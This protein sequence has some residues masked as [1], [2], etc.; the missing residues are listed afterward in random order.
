[1]TN[2]EI[3]FTALIL[4]LSATFV[5]YFLLQTFT[6]IPFSEC[7]RKTGIKESDLCSA[8]PEMISKWKAQGVSPIE[9]S[10]FHSET[11]HLR[12]KKKVI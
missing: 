12:F 10:S 5:V 1:M 11:Y 8:N 6:K 9:L 4:L 3:A 2:P 7:L